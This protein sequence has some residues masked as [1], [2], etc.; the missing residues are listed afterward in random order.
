M[1]KKYIK[2]SRMTPLFMAVLIVVVLITIFVFD[3]GKASGS[4]MNV[5]MVLN[6]DVNTPGW[7]YQHYKSLQNA[8]KARDVNLYFEDKVPEE[9]SALSESIKKLVNKNCHLIFLVSGNYADIA[10]DIIDEYKGVRFVAIHSIYDLPNLTIYLIKDYQALYLAGILAGKT[11]VSGEAA[12]VGVFPNTGA[13]WQLDAFTLGMQSVNPE[14]KVWITWT[15]DWANP[16]KTGDAVV[17]LARNT[18]A[19]VMLALQNQESVLHAAEAMGIKCILENKPSIQGSKNLLATINKN[20]NAV[21]DTLLKYAVQ[22]KLENISRFWL[23]ISDGVVGLD[24]V[25]DDVDEATLE[26]IKSTEQEIIDGKYIFSG[27][28]YDNE[29]NLICREN[30]TISDETLMKTQGKPVK[31]VVLYEIK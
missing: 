15:Y 17:Q 19:D 5:G 28:I 29:N 9:A 31:G 23:G 7:N 8:C 2:F 27:T 4:D 26:L 1:D 10:K 14:A 20:W 6:A 12:F 11:S 22:K 24:V 25:S 3:I 21:Y 13:M 30:E 18:K 16:E